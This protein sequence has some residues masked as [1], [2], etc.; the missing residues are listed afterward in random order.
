MCSTAPAAH[1][2]FERLTHSISRTH[3]RRE[4]ILAVLNHIRLHRTRIVT[5]TIHPRAFEQHI[6]ETDVR[7]A[8]SH[9][10]HHI[11]S[12]HFVLFI[13]P[14]SNSHFYSLPPS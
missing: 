6:N 8:S 7:L 14:N 10:S 13:P 2:L 11:T 1:N 5:I 4:D 3:D 12:N 9:Y